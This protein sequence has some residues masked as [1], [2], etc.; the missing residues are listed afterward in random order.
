[1]GPCARLK[2]RKRPITRTYPRSRAA[3]ARSASITVKIPTKRPFSITTAV[4]IFCSASAS[5]TST[6]GVSG[7]I[8]YGSAVIAS[9]TVTAAG[10][11]PGKLSTIAR[12]RSLTIPTTIP[13]SSTGKWRIRCSRIRL[14]A[15]PI[16]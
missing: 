14:A 8:A 13:P 2:A 3:N 7:E 9:A 4:P 1:M 10:S 12:S 6:S 15:S 16:V 11:T 5:T